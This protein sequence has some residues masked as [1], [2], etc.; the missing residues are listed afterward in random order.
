MS[1]ATARSSRKPD[2]SRRPPLA[3]A[4]R[5]LFTRAAFFLTLVLVVSRMTM[6]EVL[7]SGT[8]PVPGAPAAPATP[9]PA[10]SLALDLLCCLPALLVLARGLVDRGFAIRTSRAHVLMLLLAGWT[11]LSVLWSA[12]KFAALVNASH[13]AAALVLLW[14]TSQLVRSWLRLRVIGAVVFG[15]LMVLLAQG[16]YYRFVD[17]PDFQA[18]WR[19]HRAELLREQGTAANTAEAGQLG[20]NIESGIPT[21]FSVS[22]NTYAA[23]LV[24]LM[25]ISAGIALQRRRDGAAWGWAAPVLGVIALGLFMLYRYVQSKTAFAT[26]LI[27]AGLL[28][29]IGR[30]WDR[31]PARARRLYWTGVGLFLLMAAAVVGHGLKHGTMLQLSLT[32]RWQYWVGAARVFVHHPWV[33]VGWA[34]FGSHYPAFRLPQAAEEPTDPHNFLVRAFVE[35]GLI[36]GVLTVAWMLRLWWEMTVKPLAPAENSPAAGSAPAPSSGYSAFPFFIALAVAA[37]LANALVSI[38]WSVSPAWIL[39]ESFKRLLFLLALLIGMCLAAVRGLD[40][41]QLDDRPAPWLLAAVLVGLGLFLLHNLIDFSIFESGPMHLFALLAGSALGMRLGAAA[42]EQ[43]RGVT[44]GAFVAGGV[45]SV[46]AAGAVWAPVWE[47]EACAAD[48]DQ[49]VLDS[50]PESAPPE[51]PPDSTKLERATESYFKAFRLVPFNPDYAFR[52]EQSALLGRGNPLM[53][54]QLIDAAVSADPFA[55][56]YRLARAVLAE[57][58]NDLAQADADYRRILQLDPNNLELRL[59]YAHLLE[60]QGRRPEAREQYRQTLQFNDKLPPDEIRRLSPEQLRQVQ[61][62][63]TLPPTP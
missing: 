30:T 47:A 5:P 46:V 27:G 10:T 56:R 44:M 48:A 53:M 17:L 58:V 4:S 42:R 12:D 63:M 3:Q 20:R 52:A 6:Q 2:P 39:V 40:R 24:L 60:K 50:K 14:S 29:L 19:E 16:Y 61:K 11:L 21:G 1:R 28:A 31:L 54:R 59:Q 25:L 34:N 26:P 7:R 33:G 37:M 35:L 8:L 55:V 13:W 18:N 32:Y 23:V 15:L 49:Q 9:G 62:A 36:G 22:R 45:A 41:Q 57:S 51:A 38:D 43:R